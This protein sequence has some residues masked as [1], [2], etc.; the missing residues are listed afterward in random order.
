MKPHL[1]AIAGWLTTLVVV[2]FGLSLPAGAARSAPDPDRPVARDGVIDLREWS[3]QDRG[4]VLL[5]GEWLFHWRQL[6]GDAA[7]LAGLTGGRP[8]RMPAHW[9]GQS[10]DGERLGGEGFATYRLVLLL[11]QAAAPLALTLP[12]IKFAYDLWLDGR[13][14]LRMGRPGRSAAEEVAFAAPAVVDLPAGPG[15]VELAL[16]V[17]NH[18][19]FE[20]GPGVGPISLALRDEAHLHDRMRTSY[21]WFLAGIATMVAAFHLFML[22]QSRRDASNLLLGLMGL[23]IAARTVTTAKLQYLVMPDF[24]PIVSTT[25]EYVGIFLLP[26]LMV[27]LL[28]VLFPRE[29]RR[30]PTMV[31]ATVCGACALYALSTTPAAFTRLRDPFH[32]VLIGGVLYGFLGV[33]WATW[34]RRPFALAMLVPVGLFLASIVNDVLLYR[35]LLN[36]VDLIPTGFAVLVAGQAVVLGGRTRRLLMAESSL[37]RQLAEANS[38]LEERIAQRTAELR[39]SVDT[40]RRREEELEAANQAKSRFLA[41]VSHEIRTPMNGVLGVIELLQSTKLDRRQSEFLAV[42]RDCSDTL[43]ILIDDVLDMSR[44]ERRRLSLREADFDPRRLVEGVRGLF[45]SQAM[46]AGLELTAAVDAAV[47]PVLRGD[48]PRLRQV[49]V[50]LVGNALKFTETGGI[51]ISLRADADGWLF[52]VRDTG[53]GI[54]EDERERIFDAFGQGRHGSERGGL[55]L[56]LAISRQLVEAMG[57]R[58]ACGPTAD[59]GSVFWFVL[60]LP[61]GRTRPAAPARCRRPLRLLLADDVHANRMVMAALLE[62]DGHDVTT[63]DDGAEAVAAAAE[64]RFDAIL[65]DVRMPGM[66]GVEATRRIRALPDRDKAGVPVIG[67]TA[68]FFPEDQDGWLAAGMTAVIAKPVSPDRLAAVLER[69]APRQT[70][71]GGGELIDREHLLMLID[72]LGPQELS[73]LLQELRRSLA[74]GSAAVRDGLA[75]GAADAVAQA[76][77]RIAGSAGSY[78]LPRLADLAMS[79][80]RFAATGDLAGAAGL[81]GGLDGVVA[82]SLVAIERDETAKPAGE[83]ALTMA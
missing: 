41:T 22:L 54:A 40:L 80:E 37:T 46:A 49:L 19:H 65:M 51:G 39:R 20:G 16:T 27:G 53:V 6:P 3:F 11:P 59:G 29:V 17:S 68:Q 60:P 18:Y 12:E 13:R 28:H 10:I 45:W 14:V 78:G 36:T 74:E 79:I 1:P 15:R 56:G 58:I 72:S 34:R 25:S 83:P 77:H 9:N 55:G 52:E 47:P 66:N 71:G 35:G 61:E 8:V 32:Y 21:A 30:L 38:T 76:A 5:K 67:V 63:V 2:L 23:I 81:A 64:R 70:D 33:A 7:A 50:N 26:A 42:A 82:D 24:P 43:L 75:R 69:A 4:R 73:R 44:I 48:A 57:G 62:R 31:L